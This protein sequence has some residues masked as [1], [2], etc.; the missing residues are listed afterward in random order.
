[1]NF[2]N[3]LAVAGIRLIVIEN[4][5]TKHYKYCEFVMAC[6]LLRPTPSVHGPAH[7]SRWMDI[8]NKQVQ[9]LTEIL[10]HSL[11]PKDNYI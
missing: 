5:I 4:T 1:M 8:H 11:V 3:F 10:Y 7:W 9:I 6:V 2:E